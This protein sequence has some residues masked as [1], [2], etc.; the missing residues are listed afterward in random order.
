LISG[1]SGSGK[2]TLLNVLSRFIPAE[3]R[4]VTV[5]DSAELQL[6]RKHVVRLETRP[7]NMEGVGEVRARD[8]VR[9]A[10]RMRPDRIIVGEVRGG[11]ALDMLQAM[12]TGH[13]GSLTTI[14][15]N[16]T[17]DALSRLE[18]MVMMAGFEIPVPVIRQYIGSA[19]TLVIQL[20][21][22]KGGKRRITR[23]SEIEGLDPAPYRIRDIFGFRQTGVEQGAAV[24]EFFATGDTPVLVNRLKASGIELPATLFERRTIPA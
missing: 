15:A 17:N 11:E 4:L 2:T 13:E 24:G 20:A 6:Q 19:I 22:L 10:L 7:P 16:D 14:H 18:M 3:E 12:N 1:G 9:N 23:I 5:E 8:L 21:R